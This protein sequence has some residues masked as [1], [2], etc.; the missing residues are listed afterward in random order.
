[1]QS[2]LHSFLIPRYKRKTYCLINEVIVSKCIYTYN[3]MYIVFF[4]KYVQLKGIHLMRRKQWIFLILVTTCCIV[5]VEKTEDFDIAFPKTSRFASHSDF[6]IERAEY[7]SCLLIRLSAHCSQIAHIQ[8]ENLS[9]TC[10]STARSNLCTDKHSSE[11]GR[12]SMHY[13]ANTLRL[14]RETFTVEFFLNVSRLTT[15]LF[16]YLTL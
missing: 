12:E 5:D 15:Q 1:M 14:S 3:Y 8:W 10:L 9:D 6:Y 4:F 11:E 13:P 2:P 7:I 16:L